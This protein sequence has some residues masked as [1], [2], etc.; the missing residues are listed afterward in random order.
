VALPIIYFIYPEV[1]GKSLEEINL[2]FTSD[3]LLV[4]ENMKEYHRLLDESG[5]N[6]AVAER[7]LLDL[8]DA[9]VEGKE[10]SRDHHDGSSDGKEK[11]LDVEHRAVEEVHKE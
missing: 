3:S 4:S 9:E 2:L 6:V 7:R 5:G 8:V 11:D 1:S 10:P